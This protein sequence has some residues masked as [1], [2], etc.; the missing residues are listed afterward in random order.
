MLAFASKDNFWSRTMVWKKKNAL[1]ENIHFCEQ[2]ILMATP[3]EKPL[4]LHDRLP[5]FLFWY[6]VYEGC[7][8]QYGSSTKPQSHHDRLVEIILMVFLE[9]IT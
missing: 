8:N 3:P 9:K 4:Y 5:D 6:P 1:F 2:S 7:I